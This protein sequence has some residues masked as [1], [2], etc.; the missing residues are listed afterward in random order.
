MKLE[1]KI[2]KYYK[3]INDIGVVLNEKYETTTINKDLSNRIITV[4]DGKG[5]NLLKFN[6][7]YVGSYDVDKE[8]WMWSYN[9]FSLDDKS[10]DF[11]NVIKRFSSE[12]KSEAVKY[13]DIKYVER[14]YNYLSNEINC[15]EH[16]HILDI[17]KVCVYALNGRGIV[18]DFNNTSGVNK[19]DFY[20]VMDIMLNN[21]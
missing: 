6:Y 10:T 7:F 20:V 12:I 14:I 8:L 13:E 11:R 9:N 15:V 5:K 3:K 21:V 2:N 4:Q 19:L 17:I 18:P 1:S 16:K